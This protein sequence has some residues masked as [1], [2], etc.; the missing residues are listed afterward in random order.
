MMEEARP[1]TWRA[2][3]V[4]ALDPGEKNRSGESGTGETGGAPSPPRPPARATPPGPPN[5]IAVAEPMAYAHSERIINRDLKRANV[6]VGAF[7]ET[8]VIDWGLAKDLNAPTSAADSS[9]GGPVPPTPSTDP[10][11]SGGTV[12]G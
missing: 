2:K 5:V 7:G 12:E 6:L 3:V 10:A 4:Y 9:G 1:R 8:V 11:V